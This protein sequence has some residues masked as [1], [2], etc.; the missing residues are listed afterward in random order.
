MLIYSEVYYLQ[1]DKEIGGVIKCKSLQLF[2]HGLHLNI[3][4]TQPTYENM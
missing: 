2:T 3:H 4:E 1:M